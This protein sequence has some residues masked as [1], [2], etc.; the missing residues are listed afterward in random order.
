MHRRMAIYMKLWTWIVI[1][2]GIL[3]L[4]IVTGFWQHLLNNTQPT[5]WQV[6]PG[7]HWLPTTQG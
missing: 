3:V 4:G 6:G 7:G 5:P 2:A 1:G